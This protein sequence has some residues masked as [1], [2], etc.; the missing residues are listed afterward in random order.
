[1]LYNRSTLSSPRC[2][3]GFDLQFMCM[4]C[5]Y[6]IC[7]PFICWPL[8][9]LSFDLRIL[10]TPLVSS[11]SYLCLYLP[12][13]MYIQ[14]WLSDLG[15]ILSVL[16]IFAISE[17]Y[18]P[19]ANLK[20]LQTRYKNAGQILNLNYTSFLSLNKFCVALWFR[21]F[22]FTDCIKQD[23]IIGDSFGFHLGNYRRLVCAQ[24]V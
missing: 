15:H 8:C 24:E 14:F 19:L 17:V 20:L 5:I 12:K 21:P 6:T 11:N 22:R 16:F 3:V 18:P 10:M 2:L 4:F 13:D 1:M 7:L 23:V 9:C